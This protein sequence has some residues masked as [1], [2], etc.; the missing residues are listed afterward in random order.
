MNSRFYSVAG[1]TIEVKSDYTITDSTF[2]PKFKTFKVDGRG[3]DNVIIYHHFNLPKAIEDQSG[4]TEIYRKNQW[5]IFKK[6]DSWIYKYTDASLDDFITTI[7]GVMNKDYTSIQ[8]YTNDITREQYQNG[9]FPGLTLFNTDQMIFTKLL[10]DRSGIMIHSNGFDINGRGILLAGVS[11]SG[12]STLSRMLKEQGYEILCDDRMFVRQTNEKFYIY[13]NWCYGSHPDVSSSSAP[14]KGF[15]FLEK[16]NHN[17]IVEIKDKNEIS[18]RLLQVI[19]KPLLDVDGWEK[20]FTM[21]N[22]LR[23]KSRFFEIEFDLSGQICDDIS[24][25]LLNH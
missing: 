18:A 20:H 22:Q 16:S 14:L 1:I 13:G 8:I 24:K 12:K 2:H 25:F 15:F 3:Q 10:S 21:I 19:V 9:L 5:Q 23:K 11:G 6:D 7:F 4:A 17:R